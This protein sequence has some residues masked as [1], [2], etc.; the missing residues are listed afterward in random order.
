MKR[1]LLFILAIIIF[2]LLLDW[3]YKYEIAPL[4]EYSGF[5]DYSTSESQFLS[6]IYLAIFIPFVLWTIDN[7]NRLFTQFIVSFIF[8]L[9]IVPFTSLMMYIPQES[10]YIISNFTYWLLLLILL[11]FIKPQNPFGLLNKKKGDSEVIHIIAIVAVL[12]VLIVSGVYCNFRIHLN[13]EDVYELRLEAREFDMPKILAYLLGAT[14]NIIPILMIFYISQKKKWIVYFLAFI[15]LMNFSIAGQKSTLFKI[16]ICLGLFSLPNL[17]LKKILPWVFI[18]LGLITVGEYI[19]YETSFLSATIIRRGFFVTAFL[20]IEYF[21]YI[22]LNGPTYFMDNIA[23]KLGEILGEE[24]LSANNGLF[25][26][27]YM[28]FGFGGCLAFPF[29]ISYFIA[30]LEYISNKLDN[31]IKMFSAFVIVVTLASSSF[32][33]SMLTHGLFLLAITLYFMPTN[34]KMN[35]KKKNKRI[36]NAKH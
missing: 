35:L 16:L 24:G 3:I 11:W 5:E 18:F 6:Y 2:R 13:L 25:S 20:D 9:R 21:D 23:F 12:T 8:F 7:S 4:Y 33:T 34:V 14:S 27:A 1:K 31:S 26:D 22:N 36:K 32:T 17:N 30:L 19:C 15:G 10:F 29:I 28:N